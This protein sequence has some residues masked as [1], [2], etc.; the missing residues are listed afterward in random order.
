[1]ARTIVPFGPQHPVLPEPIHVTV[2]VE[3]EII[4]DAVPAL[5]Y[6]HRGLETLADIRDHVQMIQVVERVCGICSMIHAACYVQGI[7][8]MMGVEVPRRAEYLR[9]IWSELHRMHSHLLW[10]GLYA[11]AFGFESLF[12]Q[13]WRI[14]E[15]VMDV[16]EA[17][18][19]ARV[20]ISVN[21]IG[22]VRRDLDEDQC[23]W[24]LSEIEDVE[25]QIRQLQTTMLN[26]YSVKKR[27]VDVGVITKE[28]ALELGAAGP[29]LRGSGVAQDMRMLG[30]GAYDDMGFEP[31][32]ETAGDCYARGAVRFRETLQAGEI[33]RKAIAG[34]PEG[35]TSVK[36]RG[37]PK[38]EV[39]S[40]VEQ[41]RGELMY[42]IKADGSKNLDR[43]R[44]RTPTFANIPP[45]T[46]MLPGMELADVPVIILSIDPCISCTER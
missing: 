17:T 19:G 9:V 5:G 34:L 31:I 38:G 36:V 22:G 28:Q 30:Y 27:T 20:I 15:R 40:R 24:V 25:K 16:M 43:L 42:Y 18:A 41:P 4:T 12:M 3:D 44:I 6:V 33:I 23:K 11:D 7:E 32:V 21:V 8:E 45:L 13:F 2:T 29:C 39:I 10:L 37:R 35:E 46:A 14:R 1:M 26:D